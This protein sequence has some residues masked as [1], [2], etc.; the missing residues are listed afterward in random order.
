ML[1]RVALDRVLPNIRFQTLDGAHPPHIVLL[2]R[3]GWPVEPDEWDK[4]AL[5]LHEFSE[6][7]ENGIAVLRDLSRLAFI[8]RQVKL[9]ERVE[10]VLDCTNRD[11]NQL[12]PDVLHSGHSTQVQVDYLVVL[13]L[14]HLTVIVVLNQLSYLSCHLDR[15]IIEHHNNEKQKACLN[16]E[17]PTLAA[18][19][20]LILDLFYYNKRDA[21]ADVESNADVD[22]NFQEINPALDA[23]LEDKS[24]RRF[25]KIEQ[26][27]RPYH[28]SEQLR[29]HQHKQI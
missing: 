17:L 19:K 11:H 26:D 9:E 5:V 24:C 2:M 14:R 27:Q 3:F 25:H 20:I 1:S 10:E 12:D 29:E 16:D 28:E 7:L 22:V 18:E 23:L 13:A 6:E 4:P 8:V 21:K 15:K